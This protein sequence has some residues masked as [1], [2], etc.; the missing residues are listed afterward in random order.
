MAE[1]IYVNPVTKKSIVVDID[2]GPAK[3]KAEGFLVD[4]GREVLGKIEKTPVPP[5]AEPASKD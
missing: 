2:E 5:C 4:L 1:K 3:E